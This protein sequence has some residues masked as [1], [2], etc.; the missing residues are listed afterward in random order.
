MS[1]TRTFGA[2]MRLEVRDGRDVIATREAQNIVVRA[3]AQLVAL[4]VAGQDSAPIDRVRVGFGHEIADV[5]ATG[6]S[7]PATGSFDPAALTS[8]IAPEDFTV[9][10]DRPSVVVISLSSL[11]HLTVDLPGVSEAGL[12]AGD[13]MYNQVVFEPVTLR[14]GQ[15]VTF[16]WEIQF[17][18]GH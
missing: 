7:G 1:D 16:F 11:F 3:G 15:D 17:P 2:R 12:F 18:F 4:R 10:I 13:R 14:V 8:P 9:A 6:L 5:E